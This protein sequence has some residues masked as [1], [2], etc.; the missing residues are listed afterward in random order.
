MFAPDATSRGGPGLDKWQA[1]Q[2]L[3]DKVPALDT[4]PVRAKLIGLEFQVS[5]LAMGAGFQA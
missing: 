1:L 2:F 4:M 5:S 3:L